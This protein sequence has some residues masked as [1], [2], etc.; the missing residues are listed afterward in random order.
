MTH[1][2]TTD[3]GG[4]CKEGQEMIGWKWRMERGGYW[5][6]VWDE[7]HE[8]FVNA[9]CNAQSSTGSKQEE[10]MLCAKLRLIHP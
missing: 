2:S 4:V 7:Q 3:R 6:E 10:E 5:Q 9:T 8:W 1:N